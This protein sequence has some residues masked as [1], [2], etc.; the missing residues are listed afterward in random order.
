MHFEITGI[1]SWILNI[2]LLTTLAVIIIT[3][4]WF[5]FNYILWEFIVGPCLRMLRLYKIFIHFVMY[6]KRYI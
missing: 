4:T 2:C 1:V 6:R 3:G 5:V